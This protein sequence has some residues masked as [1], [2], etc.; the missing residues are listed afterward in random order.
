MNHV[1]IDEP[2]ESCG[3]PRRFAFWMLLPNW[4]KTFPPDHIDQVEINGPTM[5]N[6]TKNIV[7]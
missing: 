5:L 1:M 7:L 2:Y 4:Y 6:K 3:P